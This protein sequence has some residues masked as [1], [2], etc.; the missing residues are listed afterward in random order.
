MSDRAFIDTNVLLYAHDRTAGR[1]HEIARDLVAGLWNERT[2][3]LSTQV[4]QELYV[5]LRRQAGSPLSAE[6]AREVIEDYLSWPLVRNDG[7]AVVR[8][9]AIEERFGISFWDALILQA[10]E[11]AGTDVVWS[12][13]LSHG[14]R[15]GSV[16]V[17]NPFRDVTA[18][19]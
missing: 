16:T 4:L 1:K 11:Q 15:Y 13:D 19:R 5:N 12:E 17:Q 18:N 10:A 6:A 9:S 7:E 3:V 2:G 8:A 14:Q